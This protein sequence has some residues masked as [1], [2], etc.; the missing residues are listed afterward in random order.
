MNEGGFGKVYRVRGEDGVIYAMKE[1]KNPNTVNKQRFEREISILTQLQHPNIVR[2]VEANVDG[3]PPQYGPWYTMEFLSGG[4]LRDYMTEIFANNVFS[5][6]WSLNTVI[7]P[8]CNAL[9]VAHN[10]G[11]YHRDLKPENIMYTNSSRTQIKITDWGLG[12]DP[13]RTSIALTQVA[14]VGGTPD[15]CAP[16]QWF[17]MNTIDGRADIYSLGVILYE[18]M[19]GRRPPTYDNYMRRPTITP[20][21]SFH[22]TVSQ[23]MNYCILRMIELQASNRYQSVWE[24]RGALQSLPD[25][26]S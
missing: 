13:N 23:G 19:T 26:Y 8:A 20:P 15:Y 3:N 11:V 24:L 9:E 7:L 2:I 6:K 10:S 21:S 16:E 17:S 4:S 1:L 18:L 22:S 25:L 5:R 14:G 12:K